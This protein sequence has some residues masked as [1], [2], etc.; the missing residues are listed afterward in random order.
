MFNYGEKG[1]DFFILLKGFIILFHKHT[2]K[3]K[4]KKQ[5]KGEAFCLV[6]K[7]NFNNEEEKVEC[8]L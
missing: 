8:Q 5:N 7:Y 6:P 1:S 3:N 2:Y 4:T